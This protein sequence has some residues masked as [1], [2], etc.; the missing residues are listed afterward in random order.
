MSNS[1]DSISF[2]SRAIACICT[3]HRM[4]RREAAAGSIRGGILVMSHEEQ[5]IGGM[6]PA[7]QQREMKMRVP[8]CISQLYDRLL[9]MIL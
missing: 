5:K 8:C 3:R 7:F 2:R 6:V 1:R 9:P 4:G